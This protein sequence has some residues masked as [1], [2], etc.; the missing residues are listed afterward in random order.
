M[1]NGKKKCLVMKII[2]RIKKS[3]KI[4]DNETKLLKLK[5]LK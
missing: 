3:I 5:Y 4:L 2:K 1:T